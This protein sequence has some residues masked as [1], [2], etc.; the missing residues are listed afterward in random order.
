MRI[1]IRLNV[2]RVTTIGICDKSEARSIDSGASGGVLDGMAAAHQL[3]VMD[4]SGWGEEPTFDL[5]VEEPIPAE[6]MDPEGKLHEQQV[7]LPTGQLLIRTLDTMT[8]DSSDEVPV[9]PAPIA[10]APGRYRVSYIH[11]DPEAGLNPHDLLR[12][13]VSAGDYEHFRK[14]HQQARWLAASTVIVPIGALWL[15]LAWP[16]SLVAFIVAFIGSF[17]VHERLIQHDTRY[18]RISAVYNEC[19]RETDEKDPADVLMALVR[20]PMMEPADSMAANGSS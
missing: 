18:H 16:L 10:L 7:D 11:S 1:R 15:G 4:A 2:G 14:T 13:R 6:I 20:Q 8:C 3:M 19:I 12:A 9:V 17:H 5:F